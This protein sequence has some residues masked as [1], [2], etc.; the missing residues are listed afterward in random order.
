VPGK[1]N[2]IRFQGNSSLVEPA[3]GGVAVDAHPI[4]NGAD[5]AAKIGSRNIR[6]LSARFIADFV[7]HIDWNRARAKNRARASAVNLL[8][9]TTDVWLGGVE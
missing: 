9:H 3:P 1:L 4:S 7:V 5:L 2:S 8:V 6:T